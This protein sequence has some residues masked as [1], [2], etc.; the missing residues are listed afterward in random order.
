MERQIKDYSENPQDI[1]NESFDI[2]DNLVDLGNIPETSRPIV[3]RVIHATGDTDY[4]DN[5]II[6][7]VA[8]EAAVNA[9]VTGK[10]IVTDVN[11]VKAGINAKV[12]DRFGGKIICRIADEVV[13][14]KARESNK[15]RAIT[16]MQESLSDISGGIV[17][18]GN[19]PTAVFSIIDL[20]RR[21][22]AVP[23]LVIAV[24]VGFVKAAESKE[25]L[26]TFL[27]KKKDIQIPYI[28]NIGRKGGSAVAVA[29]V[30]AL[31][32]I[33]KERG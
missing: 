18:I 8:V 26:M 7:P 33:A 16:S 4:A 32:N 31:I 23:A 14:Q 2:I 21:E 15:T 5:L 30:N 9:I 3:R 13:A 19:A 10:T 1:I 25:A 20:I 11:M 24:P 27:D 6:S 28:V 29:I 22:G 17:V 12:I